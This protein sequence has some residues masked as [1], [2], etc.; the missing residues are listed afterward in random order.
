MWQYLVGHG[1]VVDCARSLDEAEALWNR[2]R[3]EVIVTDLKLR[4]IPEADGLKLVGYIHERCPAA[5]L[6]LLTTYGSPL[7]E[8]EARRRGAVGF[9]HRPS[10]AEE[11]PRPGIPRTLE[12]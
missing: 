6:W 2:T 9:L 4:G 3:Y 5:T 8:A 11:R 12:S 1:L 10:L 7:L